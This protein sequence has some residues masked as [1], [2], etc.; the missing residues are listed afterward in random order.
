LR[1]VPGAELLLVGDRVLGR[2]LSAALEHD[3]PLLRNRLDLVEPETD[4]P[5]VARAE[6]V[7]DLLARRQLQTLKL[8]IGVELERVL[9]VFPP[10]ERLTEK[11]VQ[12]GKG[13][14]AAHEQPPAHARLLEELG[15][16][17]VGVQALV[18]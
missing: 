2:R 13:L 10:L 3:G 16:E 6:D 17:D 4:A 18:R 15:L 1:R 14:V 7:V 12:R 8:D 9:V 11:V 5:L